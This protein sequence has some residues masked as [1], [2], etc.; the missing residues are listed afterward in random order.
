MLVDLG[1]GCKD[2]VT[3]SNL[4]SEDSFIVQ[5]LGKPMA[6]ASGRLKYL[7]EF[8]PEDRDPAIAWPVIFFV[9]L[10]ALAGKYRHSYRYTY[11]SP[12]SYAAC[13]FNLDLRMC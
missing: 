9:L 2:I 4:V 11:I 13:Y 10:L 3:Q 6:K 7:N 12:S 1:K 8:L 5:K